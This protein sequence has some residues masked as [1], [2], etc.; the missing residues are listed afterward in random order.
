MTA[1]RALVQPLCLKTHVRKALVEFETVMVM[2]VSLG[3]LP[4]TSWRHLYHLT[5]QAP[6]ST[7]Q[8]AAVS[9]RVVTKVVKAFERGSFEENMESY[10]IY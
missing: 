1:T 3:N 5:C 7:E 6:P 8:W 4:P 2:S 9:G 10:P